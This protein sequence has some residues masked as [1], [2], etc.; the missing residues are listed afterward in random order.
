MSD[1]DRKF[2]RL[3]QEISTTAALVDCSP[4]EYRDGL[5]TIIEVLKADMQASKEMDPDPDA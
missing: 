3:A 4:A 1:I 5:V 2:E